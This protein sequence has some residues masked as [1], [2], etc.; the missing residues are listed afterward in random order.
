MSKTD[1]RAESYVSTTFSSAVSWE[2]WLDFLDY[3]MDIPEEIIITGDLNFHLDNKSDCDGRKFIE[4]LNDRGFLK[5]SMLML[6]F[7]IVNDF[8]CLAGL[9]MLS[10]QRTAK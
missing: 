1:L 4:M 3:T 9:R 10:R 6:I 2:E 5:L 7:R 8:L